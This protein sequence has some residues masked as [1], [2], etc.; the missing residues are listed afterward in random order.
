MSVSPLAGQPALASMRVNV[1]RLVTAYY[2]QRPEPAVPQQ[3]VQFGTEDI[4][5]IYAESFSGADH[6][7]RI[8]AE[9]QAIVGAALTAPAQQEIDL[10]AQPGQGVT[11][12]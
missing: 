7:C 12:E 10:I 11:H 6:L 1:P 4:Y 5:K 2:A 8:L 9:A 3:R